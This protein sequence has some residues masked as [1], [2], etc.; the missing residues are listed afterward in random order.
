MV[1]SKIWKI[2]AENGHNIFQNGIKMVP[3][4]A[5]RAPKCSKMLPKSADPWSG[6]LEHVELR[7]EFLPPTPLRPGD[8][9]G[10]FGYLLLRQPPT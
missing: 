2:E 3:N 7:G 8:L 1:L 5:S 4:D 10:K 6:V 9:A